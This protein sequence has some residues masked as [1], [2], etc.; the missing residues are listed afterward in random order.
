MREVKTVRYKKSAEVDQSDA[1]K[2]RVETVSEKKVLV[3]EVVEGEEKKPRGQHEDQKEV[4]G[5][6]EQT[7]STA[8]AGQLVQDLDNLSLDTTVPVT[9]VPS[10]SNDID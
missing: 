1:S 3:E 8:A 7:Q 6:E 4:R 10:G 9:L 2:E 5:E